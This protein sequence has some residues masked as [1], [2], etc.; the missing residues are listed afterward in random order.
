MRNRIKRIKSIVIITLLLVVLGVSSMT[1]AQANSYWKSYSV[2]TYAYYGDETAVTDF[3]AKDSTAAVVTNVTST[4]GSLD[5]RVVGSMNEGSDVSY[6]C[7]NGYVYR[8]SSSGTYNMT[9]W[10][11]EWGY[12]YAGLRVDAVSDSYT[13]HTGSFMAN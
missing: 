13:L 11:K 2:S 12:S 1:V 10:V 8:V 9:N 7:S 4:N 3:Q 5:Y 6:D